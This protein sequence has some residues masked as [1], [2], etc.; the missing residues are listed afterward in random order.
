MRAPSALAVS[1]MAACVLAAGSAAA[2]DEWKEDGGEK[3]PPD[4]RPAKKKEDPKPAEDPNAKPRR[5]L[6]EL[7]LGPAFLL[8]SG[9]VTEFGLQLNLGYALS[10][11]L[12]TKGDAFYL[13]LSPYLLVGEDLTLVAPLGLQY[14]LPLEMI[15]YEGIYVYARV[16]GGYAYYKPPLVGF[17]TGYHGIAVQPALGAKL[18]FLERFH[19]GIEPVG[20][21]IF[22]LF[23]P[24]TTNVADYTVSAFQLYIFGGAR[25]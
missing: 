6:L 25:F 13:T 14:D 11:S 16:S 21:D 9:S 15:P 10:N 5:V 22:H 7:K 18:A 3:P 4:D 19:V 12:I 1:M 2:Q 24:R 8:A 23:P 20:F 17:D